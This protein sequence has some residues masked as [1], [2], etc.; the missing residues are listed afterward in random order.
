VRRFHFGKL[1]IWVR[2]A[3]L[4]NA[5]LKDERSVARKADSSTNAGYMT[6]ITPQKPDFVNSNEV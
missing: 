2:A 4:L 3:Q 6:K 5:E 1:S